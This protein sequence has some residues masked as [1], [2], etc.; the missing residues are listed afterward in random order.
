MV[1][2]FKKR[3]GDNK[4]NK[5]VEADTPKTEQKEDASE[6]KAENMAATSQ[7]SGKK[8]PEKTEAKGWYMTGSEAKEEAKKERELNKRQPFRVRLK[9]DTSGEFIFLDDEG[10][11]FWE[12]ELRIAGRWGNFY[13]C[14]RGIDPRGCPLCQHFG[15]QHR[16]LITL[17]SVI[18]LRPYDTQNGEHREWSIKI[19]AAKNRA[20]KTIERKRQSRG[21]LIGAKYLITRTDEKVERCGDDFEYIDDV[22]VDQYKYKDRDSK[23]VHA[24]AYNY[25]EIYAPLDYETLRG[26]I[27]EASV[28]EDEAGDMDKSVKF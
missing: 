15:K 5:Y 24:Q 28:D 21:S 14:T 20:N 26:L 25:P 9:P 8:H 18:D 16:Y 7:E 3:S 19:L 6:D 23:T 13:T 11:A 10:F 17:R 4:D 22:E 12:H 1:G 2:K 27:I